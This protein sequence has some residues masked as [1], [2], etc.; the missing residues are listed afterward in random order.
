MLVA[1]ITKWITLIAIIALVIF[2]I[3]TGMKIVN[4]LIMVL[5]LAFIWYSFFTE[6]GFARLSVALSGHPLI[7]YTTGMERQDDI[8]TNDTTYYKTTKDV[9]INGKK[10]EYVKCYTK[11]IIRI[12][13]IGDMTN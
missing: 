1:N 9:V 5:M 10:Q 7:A 3:K 13:N 4:I 2:V 8:S 6:E 11:W 12:P